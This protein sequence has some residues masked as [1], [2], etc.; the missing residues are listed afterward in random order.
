[1]AFKGQKEKLSAFLEIASTEKQLL[2]SIYSK[3]LLHK[4]VKELYHKAR[5]S[6]ENIILND[7]EGEG[8]QEV[9]Y[10][11]WKL[12]YKHIDEYRKQIRRYNTDRR[13]SGASGEDTGNVYMDGF[14]SFL[15][16]ATLFYMDLVRRL[17]NKCGLPEELLLHKK[18]GKSS[19]W[20]ERVKFPHCQY[21]CHRFLVCLGDLARYNELCKKGHEAR[22]WSVSAAY[23]LEASCVWPDSGN[24]HNQLALLATYIDDP[25]L[26][27][28]HSVRS[29]AVKEPFPDAWNNLMLLFEENRSI[30]IHSLSREAHLDLLKPCEKTFLDAT[31]CESKASS[32]NNKLEGIAGVSSEMSDIWPLFVRL[33]SFFLMK[34]GLLEDFPHTLASLVR[35]LEAL[36][37]LGEEELKGTLESYQSLDPSEK[38]PNRALQLVTILIFTI[39][40]LTKSQKGHKQKEDGN[41]GCHLTELALSAIF[42]CVGRIVDRCLTRGVFKECCPLLP[43]VLVFVEWL[44]NTLGRAEGLTKDERVMS[45]MAYFFDTFVDLLNRLNLG[46]EEVASDNTAVWE[47]HELLGFDPMAHAHAGLDFTSKMGHVGDGKLRSRRIFLAA[48]RIASTQ[49]DLSHWIVY[50]KLQKRFRRSTQSENHHVSN[51]TEE[52]EEEEEE[53]EVILFEPPIGRGNDTKKEEKS[54]PVVDQ[55]ERESETF[56][57]YPETPETSKFYFDNP[58]RP[59]VPNS[60]PPSLKGWVV[61][62]ESPHPHFSPEAINVLSLDELGYPKVDSSSS[63]PRVSIDVLDAPPPPYVSP[64]P[65][66]PLLPEQ[67]G[68]GI[69]GAPPMRGYTYATRG[70]FEYAGGYSPPQ[71]GMMSSS[72]WLYHYRNRQECD[73]A[74]WDP[75]VTNIRRLDGDPLCQ[76]GYPLI[77]TPGTLLYLDSPIVPAGRGD[78]GR[79]DKVLFGWQRAEEP[80]LVLQYLK[81]REVGGFVQ[82]G[83]QFR[84]PTFMGN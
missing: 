38:G 10:S 63:S 60:G 46:A 42:I 26:A 14:K 65:S 83:S 59:R 78:T 69:L 34:S 27:L 24:P 33:I 37:A 71:G 16:E 29:L 4:D 55:H 8:L 84:G 68:D 47:D 1:M 75:H 64:P 3:G 53:E 9:E 80:A 44:V 79:D 11:L 7:H 45:A 30:H 36:M 72:E 62:G 32:S 43:A 70:P 73:R 15:Y 58:L 67:G 50:D 52:E 21:A 61:G 48:T 49:G 17:R 41:S 2:A 35:R 54:S 28:Y 12:H 13:K 23:Y 6:Y 51:T 22:D 18:R 39:H 82:P 56:S 40:C 19:S 81:E 77:S 66:A 57:F 31:S 20:T 76:W 74:M 5:S 25:F